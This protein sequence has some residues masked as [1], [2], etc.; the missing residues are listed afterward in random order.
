MSELSDRIAL[1]NLR[2][3][4]GLTGACPSANGRGIGCT[5]H[6]GHKGRHFN[7]NVNGFDPWDD[8]PVRDRVHQGREIARHLAPHMQHWKLGELEQSV[9]VAFVDLLADLKVT[10]AEARS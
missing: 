2:V 9:G 7:Q 3:T 4:L 10:H 6:R 8:D 5:Q 1:E